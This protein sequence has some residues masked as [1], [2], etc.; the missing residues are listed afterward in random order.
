VLLI[1]EKVGPDENV[2]CEEYKNEKSVNMSMFPIICYGVCRYLKLVHLGLAFAKTEVVAE[3]KV[4]D[5]SI[6]VY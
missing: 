2:P 1:Y 6:T 4:R 3:L 5:A